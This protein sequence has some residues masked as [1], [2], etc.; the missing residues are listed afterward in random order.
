MKK[1]ITLMLLLFSFGVIFQV[2]AQDEIDKFLG[3]SVQDGSKL[4]GGYV[5]PLMKSL[6]L[7]MNQSW[8]NTAKPHKVAGFDLTATV[9]LMYIP[10]SELLFDAN[11]L[12]LT[13][14]TLVDP[15]TGNAL[16]NGNIP[17]VFG[18]DTPPT[19]SSSSTI[20]NT[21]D[22]FQGPGG[23]DLE[24]EIKRNAL[25][26]PMAQLGFGLPKGTEL[27]FRLIPKI[28]VGDGQFNLFG[29]GVMHD[30]K[31][32]IPGIKNLPFDLSALVGYTKM[33]LEVPF[34][35]TNNPDQV[36][37]FDVS[38]TTIQGVISKKVAV[39]TFYGGL[40][41]NIAKS[42]LAMLGT[43]DVGTSTNIKDPVDLSFAASGFRMSAGM[44]LKLAVFTFHADY[45]LQK[46]KAL[47][48][49]FGISVR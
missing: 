40:G 21:S 2:R 7:G 22:D 46:Y 13:Q 44:R 9:S 48:V 36:G 5:T 30:I 23:L 29:I 15:G 12:G 38:S 8:Y 3:E 25:P 32:H 6:S 42:R 24:G 1:S 27:K 16:S 14:L 34:D 35:P 49:G 47:T 45:T 26:V 43:Y 37:K 10:D 41:Y 33:K 4:I 19:F 18:P 11:K 17:T 20:G 31:Q 28:D 39:L